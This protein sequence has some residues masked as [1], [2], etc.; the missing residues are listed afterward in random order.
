MYDI[1]EKSYPYIAQSRH[2]PNLVVA[3][4]DRA[5]GYCLR[6]DRR[7]VNQVG[8]EHNDWLENN[9]TELDVRFESE[10]ELRELQRRANKLGVSDFQV[11]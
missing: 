10:R 2:D 11:S 5:K 8:V 9:F 4:V 3:F 1:E 6:S 7:S